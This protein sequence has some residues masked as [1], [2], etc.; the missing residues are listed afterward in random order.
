MK[1]LIFLSLLVFSTAHARNIIGNGGGVWACKSNP[2]AA[3]S[4]LLQVDIFEAHD[5]NNLTLQSFPSTL[6]A[7]GVAD[8]IQ[9]QVERDLPAY[10]PLWKQAMDHVKRSW[11]PA[12]GELTVIDD[13][14]YYI[15]PYDR[16]CPGGAWNYVQFANFDPQDQVLINED[17]WNSPLISEME[18]GA[19]MWHEAVY[20]WLRDNYQDATSTR[21]R[22]I[23]GLLFSTESA[24]AKNAKIA[25][26][27]NAPER[28][29]QQDWFC[30][31]GNSL[32]NLIYASYAGSEFEARH[33]ALAVC[34]KGSNGFHCQEGTIKCEHVTADHITHACTV[35]NTLNFNSF[36]G[37]G[38]AKLEAEFRAQQNCILGSPGANPMFCETKPP[39]CTEL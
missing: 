16:L 24:E 13:A 6:V 39:E 35:D 17:L 25:D 31:I 20:L 3:P 29:T 8:E 21:A 4:Q 30:T 11:Q 38:R 15:H 28:S 37:R 7:A 34:K 2:T 5:Q 18:K 33:G 36:I 19:L 26:L 1:K 32:T 23:V 10:A 22:I 27:L 9:T 14:K 12:R